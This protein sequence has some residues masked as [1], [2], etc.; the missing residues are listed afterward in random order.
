MSGNGARAATAGTERAAMVSALRRVR[1]PER[2]P[3][4][5]ARAPESRCELCGLAIRDE[6]DHLLHLDERRIVCVC[7]PCWSLHSGDPEYR[8]AGSRTLWL[9]GFRLP[10][11]LWA[12]LKIPIGLAFFLRHG[13]TGRVVAL[14]PSPAGATECELELEAWDALVEENPVLAGLEPDAE[15]LLVNRIAEAPE[16][17]IAPIDECYRLVGLIKASWEGISGGQAVEQAIQGFFA[18]L[19]GRA[20][21]R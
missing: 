7:A 20:V 10:D 19:R 5:A 12:A 4:P 14:Y 1:G 16:H 8:P 9:E 21:T 18:D 13:A 15:A 6:H 17:A 11:E 3:P 2:P